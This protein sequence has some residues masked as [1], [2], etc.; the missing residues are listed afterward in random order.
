M[1]KKISNIDSKSC[2]TN[3]AFHINKTNNLHIYHPIYI[4]VA[5]LFHEK[6]TVMCEYKHP[7]I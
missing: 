4:L 2:F 1:R 5:M 7:L 6:F 3:A